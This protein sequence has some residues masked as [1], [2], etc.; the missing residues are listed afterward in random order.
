M[1]FNHPND[2][3]DTDKLS[4]RIF[5][6]NTL[7]TV[8]KRRSGIYLKKESRAGQAQDQTPPV[9]SSLVCGCRILLLQCLPP[10][11]H[12]RS[13][14]CWHCM[15]RPRQAAHRLSQHEDMAW[16]RGA[17]L[18]FSCYFLA[19]WQQINCWWLFFL[20]CDFISTE[21]SML[22][23]QDKTADHYLLSVH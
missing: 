9:L 21:I 5:A 15:G 16:G 11:H 12:K 22:K 7:W 20:F 8:T 10:A 13:S 6:T 18:P 17:F 1:L 2:M 14:T 3:D 23:T 4:L 19:F